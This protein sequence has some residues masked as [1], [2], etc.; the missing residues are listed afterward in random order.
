MFENNNIT[1]PILSINNI[2]NDINSNLN[3]NNENESRIVTID[4]NN[5]K[6]LIIE[7]L[8]LDDQIKSYRNIIKDMTDEK[9]QYESK[10]LELMDTLNQ[11][12]IITDKGN[13]TKNKRESKG[14]LTQDIIKSTLSNLLKCQETADSYTNII[15]DKRPIKEII[16]LKRK[17]FSKKN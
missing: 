12:M 4:K 17:N 9:K 10:I 11:N 1:E 2:E 3:L 14:A 7:W 13:I 6:T 5:L 8:A 15:Y 16:N